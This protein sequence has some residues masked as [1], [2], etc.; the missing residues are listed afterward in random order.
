MC[1]AEPFSDSGVIQKHHITCSCHAGLQDPFEP[2]AAA[3]S[4]GECVPPSLLPAKQQHGLGAGAHDISFLVCGKVSAGK[5]GQVQPSLLLCRVYGRVQ[6]IAQAQQATHCQHGIGLEIERQRGSL[7]CALKHAGA[8]GGQGSRSLVQSMRVSAQ[9]QWRDCLCQVAA[10]TQAM[11]ACTRHR[12]RFTRNP[13]GHGG[14]AQRWSWS[15]PQ[16][17]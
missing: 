2:S 9:R 4:S 17:W 3:R 15:T 14:V 10:S 6:E 5:H 8:D 11:E 12:D 7:A 1:P 13:E 16:R